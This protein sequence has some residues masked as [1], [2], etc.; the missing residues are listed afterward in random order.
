M[1]KSSRGGLKNFGR[2]YV[3]SKGRKTLQG[4]K[5]KRKQEIK[6]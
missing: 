5:M 6:L 1:E 4:K 2:I 3:Q